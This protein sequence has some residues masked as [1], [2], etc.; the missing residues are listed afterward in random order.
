MLVL[1]RL[2]LGFMF[3]DL[4]ILIIMFTPLMLNS[5]LKISVSLF[6]SHGLILLIQIFVLL[7]LV[8]TLLLGKFGFFLL[9]H[10]LAL[11]NGL[12]LIIVD[13]LLDGD[14]VIRSPDQ[15][16]VLLDKGI[17]SVLF[18]LLLGLDVL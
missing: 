18:V 6:N 9:E 8:L 12:N 3:I 10:P 13:L 4:S 17:K 1:V 7:L 2:D 16:F 5:F 14:G 15:V 11:F